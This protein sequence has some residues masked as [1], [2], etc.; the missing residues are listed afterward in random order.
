MFNFVPYQLLQGRRPP[1]VSSL[2]PG[3]C[4]LQEKEET[5]CSH[6]L[7]DRAAHSGHRA[8]APSLGR[9][10]E[11]RASETIA[12]PRSPLTASR[13]TH[14]PLLSPLSPLGACVRV[15]FVPICFALFFTFF[16]LFFVYALETNE[17]C[18][19]LLESM[20][21]FLITEHLVFVKCTTN[22]SNRKSASLRMPGQ[23]FTCAMVVILKRV[24][25][26]P[27]P[28]GQTGCTSVKNYR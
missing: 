26:C 15:W 21:Y 12:A 25:K 17:I 20:L 24:L 7:R 28:A 10:K 22:L 19:C 27:N 4:N 3:G 1:H 8:P 23:E 2:A 18:F 9:R 13:Y 11:A 16:R 5:H 6:S 14:F